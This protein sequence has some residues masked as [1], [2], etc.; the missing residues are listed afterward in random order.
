MSILRS[1]EVPWGAT[2][3]SIPGTFS[4][5]DTLISMLHEHHTGRY[6]FRSPGGDEPVAGRACGWLPAGRQQAALHQVTVP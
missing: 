6:F 1:L 5:G 3:Q 2:G 4:A